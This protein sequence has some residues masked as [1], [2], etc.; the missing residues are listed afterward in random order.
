MRIEKLHPHKM[1]VLLGFMGSSL[2]SL[3][4]LGG[5][6]VMRYQVRESLFLPKGF[7]LG[8]IALLFSSFL[9]QRVLRLFAQDK[10]GRLLSSLGLALGLGVIFAFCQYF[11]WK[12]LLFN[13]V[14]FEEESA[15]SYIYF[16]S[17]VHLVQVFAG[18]AYLSFM[19]FDMWK[20]SLDPIKSLIMSTNP[21][22][23]IKLEILSWSWKFLTFSWL[24]VFLVFL[25]AI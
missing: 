5:F 25:F 23:V 22:Q 7:V 1:L 16:L 11:A 2:V 15:G 12:E 19:L 18:L 20:I 13:G 8:I 4:L 6:L 17:G 24:V 3:F 14:E 9:I 10:L 21:Y